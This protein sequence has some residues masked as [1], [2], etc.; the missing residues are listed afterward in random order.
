MSVLGYIFDLYCSLSVYH[1]HYKQIHPPEKEVEL[2]QA[3]NPREGTP[4]HGHD[5]EVLW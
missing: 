5:K 1:Q 2:Q 3:Y 4:I